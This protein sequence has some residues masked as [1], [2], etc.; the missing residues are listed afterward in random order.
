MNTNDASDDARSEEEVETTPNRSPEEALFW[1]E[2]DKL[3]QQFT[4]DVD[5]GFV[6]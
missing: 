2:F 5:N 6:V 1:Q 3:I 4:C